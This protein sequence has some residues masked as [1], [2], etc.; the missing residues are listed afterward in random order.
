MGKMQPNRKGLR[1]W[2]ITCS[3]GTRIAVTDD[4]S[5][6]KI[7]PHSVGAW[8]FQKELNLNRREDGTRIAMTE[9]EMADAI[10]RYGYF[11]WPPPKKGEGP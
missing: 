4:K 2:R 9:A 8:V 7:P 10:K 1:R 6:R 3:P 5:G 11:F